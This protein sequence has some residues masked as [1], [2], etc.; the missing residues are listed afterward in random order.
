[1]IRSLLSRVAFVASV[2][3]SSACFGANRGPTGCAAAEAD[4][5]ACCVRCLQRRS[6][7]MTLYIHWRTLSWIRFMTAMSMLC[8]GSRRTKRETSFSR[9]TRSE[10]RQR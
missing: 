2:T 1:M 4:K 10:A 6:L 7:G 9:R 8:S 3:F 5:A